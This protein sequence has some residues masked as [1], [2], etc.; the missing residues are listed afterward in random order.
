MS[1]RLLPERKACERY[2][3]T[4]MTMWRWDRDLGLGFPKPIRIRGH[5][6]R[7]EAQLDAFD[8]AQS[9]APKMEATPP[10]RR[11]RHETA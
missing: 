5:K 10:R 3:V 9:K 2:G 11:P 1:K 4:P 7:D 6:Y 8:E